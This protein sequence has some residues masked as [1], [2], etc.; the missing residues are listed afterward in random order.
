MSFGTYF[1]YEQHRRQMA[2]VDTIPMKMAMPNSDNCT[3]VTA[4]LSCFGEHRYTTK[5]NKNRSSGPIVNKAN[6]VSV[7][8]NKK[9]R[10]IHDLAAYLNIFHFVLF[11]HVF[12][13]VIAGVLQQRHGVFGIVIVRAHQ[14]K[15]RTRAAE[16]QTSVFLRIELRVVQV[17]TGPWEAQR[18]L[19]VLFELFYVMADHVW[20]SGENELQQPAVSDNEHLWRTYTERLI[21]D[22]GPCD[23]LMGEGRSLRRLQFPWNFK[24][25]F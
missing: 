1:L 15:T 16:V 10:S 25:F 7:F 24:N 20:R 2:I 22:S 23:V 19:H 13:L 4:G 9:P 3:H 18:F 8:K 5:N 21:C 6:G 17:Q 11:V 14:L 12:Q